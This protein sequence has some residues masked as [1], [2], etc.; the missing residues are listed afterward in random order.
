MAGL[1]VWLSGQ[2]VL[3]AVKPFGKCRRCQGTGEVERFGKPRT[4][5]RCH[6]HRLRLRLGRR[7]HNSWRRTYDNGAR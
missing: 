1:V 5:P 4:C 6:G 2:A 3:C 7:A